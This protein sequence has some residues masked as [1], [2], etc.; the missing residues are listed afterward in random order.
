V[1][2]ERGDLAVFRAADSDAAREAWILCRVRLRVDDVDRVLPVDEHTARA[3]ELLPGVEQL[4]VL[5]EDVDAAV[6][7]VG[8]EQPSA[9]IH[10]DAVR[11]V[12][13]TGTG[14]VRRTPRLDELAILR[15]LHDAAVGVCHMTIGD[16]GVA[17]RRDDDVARTGKRL[18]GFLRDT[19]LAE[20]QQQFAIRAELEDLTTLAI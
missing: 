15:E 16:E 6:G 4:A 13:F 11:L 3:A 1:G 14:A 9:R 8:N 12:H 7:P 18:A 20:R 10:R 2:D 17:V 5:I 19:G